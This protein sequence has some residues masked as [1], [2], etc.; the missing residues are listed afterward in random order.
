[1]AIRWYFTSLSVSIQPL[2]TS[3]KDS[4]LIYTHPKQTACVY[5]CVCVG[6]ELV[7][8]L[9]VVS[10]QIPVLYNIGASSNYKHLSAGDLERCRVWTA[11]CHRGVEEGHGWWRRVMDTAQQVSSLC[12]SLTATDV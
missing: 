1:M 11:Y 7:M 2:I 8:K 4:V 6:A 10:M 5:M 3:Y 12:F 9:Q